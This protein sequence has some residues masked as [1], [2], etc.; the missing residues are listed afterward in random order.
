MN[1]DNISLRLPEQEEEEEPD[2][3]MYLMD[4]SYFSGKLE[5]YFR[6][7]GLRWR[8]VEATWSQLARLK[9][10]AGTSQ[11]PLVWDHVAGEWLRDTTAIMDHLEQ[12]GR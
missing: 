10:A 1:R 6:W 3:T 9:L 7:Q 2:F 11:V 5:T 4:I 8:R 12:A